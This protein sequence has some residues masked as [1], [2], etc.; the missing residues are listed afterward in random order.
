MPL[1]VAQTRQYDFGVPRLV[2]RLVHKPHCLSG[3]CRPSKHRASVED[4]NA[5]TEWGQLLAWL[6]HSPG[7][8]CAEPFWLSFSGAPPAVQSEACLPTVMFCF[9]S[10]C[11]AT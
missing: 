10:A 11:P 9:A 3:A 4:S 8:L 7:I 2:A 5:Y 1:Q 6:K